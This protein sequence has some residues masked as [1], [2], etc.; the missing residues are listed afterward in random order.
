MESFTYFYESI[1]TQKKALLIRI[2][3]DISHCLGQYYI[4]LSFKI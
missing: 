3:D 1:T 4:I 2:N